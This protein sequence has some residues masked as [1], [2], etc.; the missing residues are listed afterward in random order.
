MKTDKLPYSTPTMAHSVIP[1]TEKEDEDSNLGQREKQQSEKMCSSNQQ[2]TMNIPGYY[3][4]GMGMQPLA[5]LGKLFD[6]YR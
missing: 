5:R 2:Q 1:K 3:M 6:T 4:N